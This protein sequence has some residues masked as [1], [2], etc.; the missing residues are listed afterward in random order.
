MKYVAA[1]VASILVLVLFAFFA[2]AIGWRHGGGMMVQSFLWMIVAA[3]WVTVTKNWDAILARLQGGGTAGTPPALA[4]TGKSPVIVAGVIL[5]LIAAMFATIVSKLGAPPA[6]EIAQEAARIVK[7][8]QN[9]A[10]KQEADANRSYDSNYSSRP[11]DR[12]KN[13][14]EVEWLVLELTANEG[15]TWDVG[16]DGFGFSFFDGGE[17]RNNDF[18]NLTSNK[19]KITCSVLY[20][21]SCDYRTRQLAINAIK[22]SFESYKKQYPWAELEVVEKLLRTGL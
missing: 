7:A 3:V 11:W 4:V 20:T 1:V 13:P 18:L 15:H 9:E 17:V 5:I 14:T 2:A 6:T 22:Q 12:P 8:E 21:Y 19:R 16:S 10:K